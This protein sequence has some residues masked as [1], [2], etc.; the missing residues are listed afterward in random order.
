MRNK[1]SNANKQFLIGTAVMAFAVMAVVFVFICLCRPYINSEKG[2]GP[3]TDLFQIEFAKG[4]AGDTA[5]VYLNDSLV[6]HNL[7]PTDTTTL[8]VYRFADENTLM[9]SRS[10]EDAVSIFNIEKKAGRL[11]LRKSKGVVSMTTLGW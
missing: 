11:I 4:F 9:V 7:V 2:K 10:S 1:A 6:W 5:L 3:S 8:R